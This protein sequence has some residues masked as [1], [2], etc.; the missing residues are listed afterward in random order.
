[1]HPYSTS[2]SR[3]TTY[4]VLAV[5]SVV[6]AWLVGL[7][8]SQLSWPQWLVSAPSLAGV[9][10]G[11]YALT[12][13]YLWRTRL[14]RALGLCTT[15]S[16][17]GTYVGELR[18][19]FKDE[20]GQPVTRALELVITQT[21]TRV[22]ITMAVAGGSSTSRSRSAVACV[23]RGGAATRLTYYYRNL[24]NPSAADPDMGDHDGAAE[25][26]ITVDGKLSG[27]YFNSRPRAGSI[28]AK[29]QP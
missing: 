24:V 5:V 20:H 23:D 26:E 18:S 8:T 16:V 29:R 10:A 3:V 21:W 14:F 11:L 6:V 2:D 28:E 1:M 13:R 9:F 19:T 17:A 7:A 12:D 22:E 4:G 25:V 15:P 27:R